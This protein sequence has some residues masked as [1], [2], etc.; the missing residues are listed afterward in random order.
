LRIDRTTDAVV[1]VGYGP[2]QARLGDKDGQCDAQ[3]FVFYWLGV[4]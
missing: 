1:A 2:T 3:P 4:D